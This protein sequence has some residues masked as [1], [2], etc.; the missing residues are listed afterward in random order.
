M[1]QVSIHKAMRKPHICEWCG[2]KISIGDTY[3]RYRYFCYGD[4]GVVKMHPECMAAMES[5]AHNDGGWIEFTPH[6]AERPNAIASTV[7]DI[8]G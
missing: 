6:S 7:R 1:T 5:E 8:G 4:T 2:E 3:H